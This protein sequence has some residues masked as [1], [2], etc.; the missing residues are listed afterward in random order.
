MPSNDDDK[1]QVDVSSDIANLVASVAGAAIGFAAGNIPGAL[2]G[3]ATGPAIGL[4]LKMDNANRDLRM[5]R[6]GKAVDVA[7]QESGLDADELADWAAGGVDRA[8]L[9]ARVIRA[10]AD[11]RTA[12]KIAV[13]RELGDDQLHSAELWIIVRRHVLRFSSPCFGVGGSGR[14]TAV[15]SC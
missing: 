6:V 15:P 11:A 14:I 3:A 5:H 8:D 13:L 7:V 10:A 9:L 12:E 1:K 4:A 2:F